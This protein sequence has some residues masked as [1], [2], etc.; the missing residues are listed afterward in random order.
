MLALVSYG[1]SRQS[2]HGLTFRLTLGQ[3][4]A[5]PGEEID[6]VFELTNEKI[7][8]LSW[9]QIEEELPYRMTKGKSEG[10]SPFSKDRLIIRYSAG[11]F[12][13]LCPISQNRGI[14]VLLPSGQKSQ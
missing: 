1:W 10:S 2:L 3:T 12:L 8:P 5:F 7:L 9:L 11:C 4:R 13:V 6:L 14:Q